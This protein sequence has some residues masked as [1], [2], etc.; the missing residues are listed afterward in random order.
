MSQIL[1]QS[2]VTIE[3]GINRS[4]YR[5]RRMPSSHLVSERKIKK[6]V[7]IVSQRACWPLL[8]RWRCQKGAAV[9]GGYSW[10]WRLISSSAAGL[11]RSQ[12]ISLASLLTRDRNLWPPRLTSVSFSVLLCADGATVCGTVPLPRPG[13][14]LPHSS[15]PT[16]HSICKSS[17]TIPKLGSGVPSVCFLYRLH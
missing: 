3:G 7:F 10:P 17:L 2:H 12:P 9:H 11:P 6:N 13:L 1:I 14:L 16:S 4:C 15:R 8:T 5:H